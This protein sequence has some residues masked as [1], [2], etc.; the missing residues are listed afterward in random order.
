[1][2]SFDICCHNHETG[3]QTCDK[4]VQIRTCASQETYSALA[5]L[6][7]IAETQRNFTS[8]TG[9][10]W[11]RNES[12]SGRDLRRR[13]RVFIDDFLPAP[14]RSK[15]LKSETVRKYVHGIVRARKPRVSLQ[16][17]SKRFI[18]ILIDGNFNFLRYVLFFYVSYASKN[19]AAMR[20]MLSTFFGAVFR[21]ALN[22]NGNYL[23]PA[24][25]WLRLL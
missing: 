5:Y 21:A 25:L 6:A 18:I 4:S 3:Q 16:L 22:I 7:I 24:C 1:M 8:R 2:H 23:L 9:R 13:Q 20:S 10:E 14:G 15:G 11:R 12:E 17:S 19:Q